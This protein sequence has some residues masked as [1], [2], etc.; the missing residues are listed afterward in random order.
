MRSFDNPAF[1]LNIEQ[2]LDA[3]RMLIETDDAFAFVF[4]IAIEKRANPDG[5]FNIRAANSTSG[6]VTIAQGRAIADT[7]LRE[8]ERITSIIEKGM[9]KR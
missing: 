4:G 2:Q 3:S 8:A 9:R 5:S 7:L 1:N 6:A